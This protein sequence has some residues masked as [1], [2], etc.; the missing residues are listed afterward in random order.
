[1]ANL[2]YK[3]QAGF[4]DNAAV[5]LLCGS[6]DP[7]SPEDF[8]EDDLLSHYKEQWGLMLEKNILRS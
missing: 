8:N 1:M 7:G 5:W 2:E 4:P 3:K 6:D